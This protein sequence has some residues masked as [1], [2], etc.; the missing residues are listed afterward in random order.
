MQIGHDRPIEE[1]SGAT[2][3]RVGAT[4]RRRVTAAGVL[5]LAGTV[6]AV[7]VGHARSGGGDPDTQFR[8]WLSSRPEV[9]TVDVFSPQH[10]SES[11]RVQAGVAPRPTAEVTLRQSVTTRST[12]TFQRAFERYAA[13]HAGDFLFLSVV[14]RHDAFAL[15]VTPER[16]DNE[17]RSTAVASLRGTPGVVGAGVDVHTVPVGGLLVDVRAPQDASPVLRRLAA[18]PAYPGLGGGGETERLVVAGTAHEV[19][20]ARHGPLPSARALGAFALAARRSPRAVVRLSV[21]PGPGGAAASVTRLDV[22]D[23]ATVQEVTATGFGFPGHAES[24]RAPGWSDYDPTAWLSRVEATAGA[25]PGVRSARLV[26]TSSVT[27]QWA[28]ATLDARVD[29]LAALARLAAV[30]PDGV[31]AVRAHTGPVAVDPDAD[32]PLPDTPPPASA[33]RGSRSRPDLAFSAPATTLPRAVPVLRR[34]AATGR[35]TC[36]RW[37]R[38]A[39]AD[40]AGAPSLEVRVEALRRADW[41]PVLDALLAVRRDPAALQ[42]DVAIE[43]PGVGTRWVAMLVLGAGSAAP[44]A[45]SSVASDGQELRAAEAALAP[46]AAYWTAHAG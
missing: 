42:P 45:S 43:L 27:E 8:R 15:L 35:P 41:Q 20:V 24:V 10:S 13:T 36:L 29:D 40:P 7:A 33:C 3:S 32:A 4:T 2:V 12:A 23:S 34:L 18:L 25:V 21:E 30:V 11:D 28:V 26:L 16:R 39:M 44:Y 17:A 31:D 9:A 37:T 6:A 19:V 38:R 5:L 22:P 14:V 1:P 46:L